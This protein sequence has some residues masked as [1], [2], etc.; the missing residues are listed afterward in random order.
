M[1]TE[2]DT[3]EDMFG[4]FT[5]EKLDVWQEY[6]GAH[7]ADLRDMAPETAGITHAVR[8][9]GAE[10][11]RAYSRLPLGVR[12]QAAAVVF[13]EF[14]L[15]GLGDAFQWLLSEAYYRRLDAKGEPEGGWGASLVRI[16]GPEPGDEGYT[17]EDT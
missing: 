3:E 11:A 10:L 5:Q 2:E 12:K 1:D 9:H 4:A 16:D 13:Q 6:Y 17:E 8:Y 7:L 14:G 15:V